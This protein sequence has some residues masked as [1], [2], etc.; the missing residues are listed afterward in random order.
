MFLTV[1][2]GLS[3]TESF[4]GEYCFPFGG[5]WTHHSR[6]LVWDF[7]TARCPATGRVSPDNR[8]WCHP[9]CEF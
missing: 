5:V 9:P 7:S 2:G 8:N 6:E 1:E 3:L 4:R